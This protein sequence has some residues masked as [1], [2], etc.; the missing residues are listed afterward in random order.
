MTL[1][2]IKPLAAEVFDAADA[3][4]IQILPAK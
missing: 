3:L 2:D 1:D 4:R